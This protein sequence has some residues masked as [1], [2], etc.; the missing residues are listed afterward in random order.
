ML[1]IT[2][3]YDRSVSIVT[4]LLVSITDRKVAALYQFTCWSIWK[5]FFSSAD[6]G[7]GSLQNI[8]CHFSFLSFHCFWFLQPT[9]LQ[10]WLSL[11]ALINQQQHGKIV[12]MV[13]RNQRWQDVNCQ[14][15]TLCVPVYPNSSC[16]V[17]TTF[18]YVLLCVWERERES[19]HYLHDRWRS[20]VKSM[21]IRCVSL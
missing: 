2:L 5:S 11:A 17:C 8:T 20:P 3:V 15:H 14:C 9:T 21:Q 12:I 7:T 4:G 1:I 16:S 6:R 13:K 19:S 18:H 10:S